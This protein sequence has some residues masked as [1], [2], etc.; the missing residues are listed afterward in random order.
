MQRLGVGWEP[1][2]IKEIDMSLRESRVSRIVAI[3]VGVLAVF[4]AAGFPGASALGCIL[5]DNGGGTATLL[6]PACPYYNEPA[7]RYMIIAGLPVGTTIEG[8][9]PL[10]DFHCPT[11]PPIP[12]DLCTYPGGALGG[13]YADFEAFL[14]LHLVGTGT[15]AAFNR[16]ITI[17]IIAGRADYAPRVPFAPVQSFPTDLT[18]MQR[19]LTG[20]PDFD[21]LRI[22]AGSNFGMPSP[23]HTTLTQQPG[24]TWAV[25][26][27]FDV[28][29][30]IDFVGKPGGALSGMSG[31]TFATIRVFIGDGGSVPTENASWGAIKELYDE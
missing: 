17:P 26:S 10:R 15:L 7:M 28:E 25:D 11:P 1:T 2:R 8:T 22:T 16:N 12:M 14:D 13:G 19:Q 5:P 31:S 30:R 3:I 29:Y 6:N 9:G 27:F 23:G 24:G 21:L 20:D 4:F 18:S